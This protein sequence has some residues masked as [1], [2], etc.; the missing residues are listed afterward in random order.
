MSNMKLRD[1]LDTLKLH[2][3]DHIKAVAELKKIFNHSIVPI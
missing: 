1:E 3:Y 2:A